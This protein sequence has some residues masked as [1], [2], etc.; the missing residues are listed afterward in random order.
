MISDKN[1]IWIDLEMTGLDPDKDVI[2]EI[3][4]I[5]TDEQLNIIDEGPSL[6]IS[7]TPDKLAVMCEW[8][9]NLHNKS[10]LLAR[11]KTSQITQ[12]QA[13]EQTVAFI[14]RYCK[15]G[16]AILCGNSV[17]QDR[18]FLRKYMPRIVE[19]L[20]Y[21]LIDVSSVKV[22]ARRWYPNSPEKD[23]KKADTHRA[24]TD[25]RESINELK[26]YRQYFFIK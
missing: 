25:I 9:R 7:Q 26:H 24:L 6:I 16:T 19:L 11:V 14:T 3:A 12:E 23:F 8:V 5:I 17:W 10:G 13:E 22:L 18:G 15:P 21:R 20:H 1:F 4:S 2:L